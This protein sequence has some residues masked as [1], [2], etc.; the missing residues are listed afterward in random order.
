VFSVVVPDFGALLHA[1]C[2]GDCS[3][4]EPDRLRSYLL[5][6]TPT[7]MH[8]VNY[9]FRQD[10]LHRYAYD[11]ETLGQVMSDVGFVD[12]RRREFDPDLDS[13]KRRLLHSLYME[14]RKP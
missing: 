8:H 1:Y 9:W 5:T 10:G 14:G 12:V 2:R 6:E 13:E 4:F 3:F 11:A 7:L